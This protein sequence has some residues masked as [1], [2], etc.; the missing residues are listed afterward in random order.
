MPIWHPLAIAYPTLVILLA[1]L[2]MVVALRKRWR[3]ALLPLLFAAMVVAG[4]LLFYG[5]PRMRAPMEPMLVVFAA[6][7][8][9][10]LCDLAWHSVLR[11]RQASVTAQ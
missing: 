1:L 3:G 11:T 2:G 7:G 5:S 10:W 8:V 9:V 4:G 6:V